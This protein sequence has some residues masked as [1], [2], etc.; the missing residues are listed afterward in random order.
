MRVDRASLVA[1]AALRWASSPVRENSIEEGYSGRAT[2]AGSKR[3]GRPGTPQ[4]TSVFPIT[5]DPL[6]ATSR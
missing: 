4:T 5:V 2:G 1:R 3:V 6:R